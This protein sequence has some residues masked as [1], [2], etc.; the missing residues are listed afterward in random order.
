MR[1]L[2]LLVLTAGLQWARADEPLRIGLIS[3]LTGPAAHRN[4]FQNMGMELAVEQLA[5]KGFPVQLVF[6]DSQTQGV[7]AIAAYNKLVGLSKV[8]A[9]ISD[10]FGLVT[11]P[12]L[13]IARR[14]KTLLV[15]TALAPIGPALGRF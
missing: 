9:L 11:A 10:D 7:R 6:E 13:P 8:E 5:D 14:Q 15:S 4:K 3:G 12:L 1:S 2:C